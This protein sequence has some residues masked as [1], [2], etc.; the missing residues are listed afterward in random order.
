[1]NNNQTIKVFYKYTNNEKVYFLN[2]FYLDES[3]HHNIIIA[4]S[5]FLTI[6]IMIF[7]C[8]TVDHEEPRATATV[9]FV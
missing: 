2:K 6:G 7:Q 1:M 3:Y 5:V 9:V 8:A 4:S